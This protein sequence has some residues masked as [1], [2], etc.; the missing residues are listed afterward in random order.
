MQLWS[1]MHSMVAN[2]LRGEQVE[3]QLDSELRTYVEMVT[4]EKIAA[5]AS[6]SEARRM[7][8]VDFGGIEQVKQAVR[9]HRA[10]ISFEVIW[11]DVRHG[12][13]Q[14]LRNP[15][16][17]ATVIATLAL[18]IGA[19]T[20]I[21]SLVD[22]LLLKS[23]PYPHP[24][25]MGTIFMRVQGAT[26]SEGHH[27][28]DGTQ[29]ERLRDNVP[30]LILAVSSSGTNGVNLQAGERVQ[31]LRAGR[32]SQHYFDVLAIAPA[33]GRNFNETEDLPHGANAAILS[34]GVWRNI[35]GGDT[36]IVGQSIRLKGEP[37]T[38][39]GVLPKGAITP[40]NADLYTALQPSRQGEGMG[41]N[42]EVIA[43]LRDGASWQEADA[44]INRAWAYRAAS[45]AKEYP[46]GTRVDFYCVPL[47]KSQGAMLRP[48][49][50]AL[51]LAAGFIL[52]IAC[53]NLAGL[54]LVRMARRTTEIAT[55]LALGASAWQIQRQLWMENLLL[56][57]VG[58]AA[59][60]GR[61]I[62]CAARPSVSAAQRFSARSRRIS[63]CGRADL[64]A[65]RLIFD[66]HPVRNA[67]RAGCA[68]GRPSFVDCQ[69]RRNRWRTLAAAPGTDNRRGGPNRG[70]PGRFRP[71]HPHASPS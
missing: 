53:A 54:T 65:G 10:G 45:F 61:G 68:Q 17:T 36:A 7:T 8:L 57:G 58:G 23:L 38:V 1:R 44:E 3:R 71:A 15:G 43:R 26:Q 64:H 70:A 30:A 5:G 12:C 14:M 31:Y 9:D 51:M 19:N 20:A 62:C 33:L 60:R 29:W 56:A 46:A 2:L 35:F 52:L 59:G 22:A 48:Q 11:H 21:F 67:A 37:Y 18:V 16:F 4:D 24:E 66:Q 6:P 50:L 41:T 13:R 28:I 42:F 40:M 55:R 32:V 49:A 25:R 39:I 63:G 34:Y 27:W 47:Q 69:P